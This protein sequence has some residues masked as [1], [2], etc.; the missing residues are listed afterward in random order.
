[1]AYRHSIDTGDADLAGR[2]AAE[3]FRNLMSADARFGDCRLRIWPSTHEECDLIG[4]QE[5]KLDQDGLLSMAGVFLDASQK[6]AEKEP[7]PLSKSQ[8]R[9]IAETKERH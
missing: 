3:K 5:V 8:A 9:R 6:L 7:V 2:W 4:H 1:M